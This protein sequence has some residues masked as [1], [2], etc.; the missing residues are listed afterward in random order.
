MGLP[1]SAFFCIEEH[2]DEVVDEGVG[3]T[4]RLD[5]DLD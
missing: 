3:S 1:F 4:G 5:R 2:S